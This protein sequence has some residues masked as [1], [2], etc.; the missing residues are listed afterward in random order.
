ML[1]KNEI[2]LAHLTKSA[3]WLRNLVFN[4]YITNKMNVLVVISW[5]KRRNVFGSRLAGFINNS[6][7]FA[8][9]WE[10][11]NGFLFHLALFNCKKNSPRL[12]FFSLFFPYFFLFLIKIYLRFHLLIHFFCFL[13]KLFCFSAEPNIF[14]FQKY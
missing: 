6:Y 3:N 14:S 2:F 12:R 1:N 7:K 8:W 9:F 13:V 4:K 10:I 5:S 11:P